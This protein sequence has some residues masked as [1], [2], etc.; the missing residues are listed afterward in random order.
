MPTKIPTEQRVNEV[1]MDHL[2]EMRHHAAAIC[3]R[4]CMWLDYLAEV[5]FDFQ[6]DSA[7]ERVID[8]LNANLAALETINWLAEQAD[9]EGTPGWHQFSL[10]SRRE[11]NDVYRRVT[12]SVV[13]ANNT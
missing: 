2:Y 1:T 4:W 5:K 8:I 11:L 6:E 10:D 3:Y 7:R 9:Q 13:H 12:R